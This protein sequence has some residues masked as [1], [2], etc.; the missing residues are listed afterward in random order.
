MNANTVPGAP[1]PF[2]F[3]GLPSAIQAPTGGRAPRFVRF[4]IVTRCRASVSHDGVY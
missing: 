2:T 3:R 1:E 4:S